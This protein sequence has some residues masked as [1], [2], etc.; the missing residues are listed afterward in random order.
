MV[1]VARISKTGNATAQRGDLQGMTG[2]VKVGASGLEVE[3]REV[4]Q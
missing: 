1:V 3:I 4:V 2:P